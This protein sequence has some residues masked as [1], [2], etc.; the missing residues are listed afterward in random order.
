MKTSPTTAMAMSD[1]AWRLLCDRMRN[2]S[3]VSTDDLLDFIEHELWDALNSLPPQ[4]KTNPFHAGCCAL[5]A[6][7]VLLTVRDRLR[8]GER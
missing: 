5:R 6:V 1:E 8:G 2:R 3:S 7:S 4:D